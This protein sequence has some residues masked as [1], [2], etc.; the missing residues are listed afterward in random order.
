MAI[1]VFYALAWVIQCKARETERCLRGT[2]H[3]VKR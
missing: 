3:R 2:E 1:K